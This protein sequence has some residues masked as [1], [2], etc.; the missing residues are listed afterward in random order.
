[1]TRTLV[2]RWYY[3]YL[4]PFTD[5]S[6]PE[7]RKRS[8]EVIQA[9][10]AATTVLI[11]IQQ[12]EAGTGYMA[13]YTSGNMIPNPT[14]HGHMITYGTT[15]GPPYPDHPTYGMAYGPPVG[16]NPHNY[17]S[18]YG[19]P[20]APHP[21]SYASPYSNP[22]NQ[23]PPNYASPYANPVVTNQASGSGL[24]SSV[25]N[26]TNN[27][28]GHEICHDDREA[29]TSQK[30]IIGALAEA[31]KGND[32]AAGQD[33]SNGEGYASKANRE[34]DDQG[35]NNKKEETVKPSGK[36]VSNEKEEVSNVVEL[37]ETDVDDANK[38]D[39]NSVEDET[40]IDDDLTGDDMTTAKTDSQN[41]AP[42]AENHRLFTGERLGDFTSRENIDWLL[43]VGNGGKIP[44]RSKNAR[45]GSP[46]SNSSSQTDAK[47]QME[48]DR[49][50]NEIVLCKDWRDYP[51]GTM[52]LQ[53]YA[54]TEGQ[55][56][57][58]ELKRLMANTKPVVNTIIPQAESQARLRFYKQLESRAI[59]EK[60]DREIAKGIN[61][62]YGAPVQMHQ[63]G[64]PPVGFPVAGL[65]IPPPL[66]S[67]GPIEEPFVRRGNVIAAPPGGRNIEEEK[68]AE[69][70]GYPPTPGSRP[71]ASRRSQKRKRAARD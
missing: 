46:A 24:V 48:I 3:C 67:S 50:I 30:D 69:T 59:R 36:T 13:P 12:G 60:R 20:V 47:I 38:Q 2:C 39:S 45:M 53:F 19:N 66:P 65:P 62:Y 44:K 25:D 71:G 11:Q 41:V 27:H 54:S 22:V 29:Y 5:V 68:K 9:L 23:P 10:E 16:A 14:G 40:S 26:Q 61:R 37:D 28:D 57:A 63:W 7:K 21:G 31:N 58:A 1:M 6:H 8:Q 4:A 15:Y 52:K 56:L 51:G 42:P 17:A 35:V 43:T 49:I 70:F 33:L 18:P 55:R 32:G 64:P 34:I